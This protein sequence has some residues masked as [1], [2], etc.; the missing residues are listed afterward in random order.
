[1]KLKTY[2]NRIQT[3]IFLLQVFGSYYQHSFLRVLITIK[4]EWGYSN[5]AGQLD[6]GFFLILNH[7]QNVSCCGLLFTKAYHNI[8]VQHSGQC[9]APNSHLYKLGAVDAC[10]GTKL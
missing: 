7:V 1:M 2:Y 4:Q 10:R 8:S 6:N 3:Y 5:S 9:V